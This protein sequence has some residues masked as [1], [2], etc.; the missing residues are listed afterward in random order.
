MPN[1]AKRDLRAVWGTGPTDVYA[2]GEGG[3]LL[4]FDGAKWT[5]LT[6]PTTGLLLSFQEG[7]ADV[8]VVA[9]AR[10]LILEGIR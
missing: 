8:P 10:G 4:R 5:A 6:S 7:A 1:P 3:V 2:A 9:G